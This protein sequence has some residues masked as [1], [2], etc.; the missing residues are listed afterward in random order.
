M[1]VSA[2]RCWVWQHSRQEPRKA[3]KGAVLMALQ[4]NEHDFHHFEDEVSQIEKD[5]LIFLEAIRVEKEETDGQL[6]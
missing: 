4:S 3:N 6:T 2:A 5:V 1:V